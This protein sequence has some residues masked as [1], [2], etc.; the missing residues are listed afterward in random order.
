MN[1][2]YNAFVLESRLNLQKVCAHVPVA[3]R[4]ANDGSQDRGVLVVSR[5]N[6][7]LDNSLVEG[8]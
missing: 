4:R 7:P 3:S 2:G 5:N 1:D 6:S 8:L